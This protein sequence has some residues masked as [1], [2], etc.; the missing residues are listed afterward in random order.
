MDDTQEL[1][2]ISMAAVLAAIASLA[3]LAYWL[4]KRTRDLS[5]GHYDEMHQRM[6]KQS[7]E[8]LNA[9]ERMRTGIGLLRQDLVNWWRRQ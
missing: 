2:M 4:H 7:I 3:W 6:D 8:H 1:V 9:Y 5:K